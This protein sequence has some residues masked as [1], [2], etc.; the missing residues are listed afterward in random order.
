M[1]NNQRGAIFTFTAVLIPLIMVFTGI[2]IDFG[3][4]Y[5]H[6]S[7]LQNAADSAALAGG[8]AFVASDD[9]TYNHP[10]ANEAAGSY[11]DKN[12]PDADSL[13]YLYQS[14]ESASKLIYF[15][16]TLKEKVP[17]YFL[18]YFPYLGDYVD[19]SAI[20]CSRFRRN[21]QNATG[22]GSSLFNNL[23][24]VGGSFYSI[25]AIQNYDNFNIYQTKNNCST[26]DGDMVFTNQNG[27]NSAAD[28][29]YL[30]SGAFG[31]DGNS[32]ITVNQAKEQGYVN[33]MKYD[34]SID[35]TSYYNT[36]IKSLMSLDST[37]KITDQNMQN[38]N[39]DTLNNLSQ[40]GVNV[41]YSSLP[42]FNIS[43]SDAIVG[44]SNDPLY[45]ICDN[46]NNFNTSAN[47]LNGRPIVFV[48]TGYG[49]MWLNC[50][51]GTFTGNIY[52]PYGSVS[53]NDNRYDFYGSIVVG[54]NLNLQSQGYYSQKNYTGPTDDTGNTEVLLVDYKQISWE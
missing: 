47:M 3:N 25:N 27:Y 48:Y 18:R 26:Y 44:S 52:A 41:I 39:S 22:S 21:D 6:H 12:H 20:G 36:T 14:R 23:F 15:R 45:I 34:S 7:R 42:N 49:N 53:V 8:Y 35:I 9:E 40:Q 31:A 19:I 28:K 50:N 43:L 29:I 13:D 51:G 10:N 11:I 33:T 37:Y 16:V 17:L 30:K 38:L 54:Q 4:L 5:L 24:T 32:S 46:I 1:I 2:V